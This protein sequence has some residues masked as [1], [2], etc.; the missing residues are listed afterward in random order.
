MQNNG[1]LKTAKGHVRVS[2]PQKKLILDN[3]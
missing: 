1:V 3:F 2:V